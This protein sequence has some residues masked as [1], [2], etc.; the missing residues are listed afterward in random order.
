MSQDVSIQLKNRND[1][2]YNLYKKALKKAIDSRNLAINSYL[3]IKKFKNM[4]ILDKLTDED[5]KEEEYLE[6]MLNLKY[7]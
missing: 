3:E 7:N 6:S 5:I 2:Y 1:I 4:F